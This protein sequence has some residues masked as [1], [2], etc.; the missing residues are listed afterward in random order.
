MSDPTTKNKVASAVNQ[1]LKALIEGT[2]VDV[3]EAA[4][5]AENPWL[6]L[7]FI[8]QIFH[9]IVGKVAAVIYTNAALAATKIII[10]AQVNIEEGIV[11][12]AFDNL[13][14]AIASG[15]E[16]AIVRASSDLSDAYASLI[17]YDGSATP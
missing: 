2:G 13:T 16:V 10:D 8:K 6:G 7:P 3:L 11:N 1:I 14:M 4:L 9:F 5:I 15:D 12:G 17:H